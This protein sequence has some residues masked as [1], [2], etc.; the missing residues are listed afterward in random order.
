VA[1]GRATLITLR[2]PRLWIA[3]V[4]FGGGDI[5]ARV[6]AASMPR[7]H[8]VAGIFT[9]MLARGGKMQPVP[10]IGAAERGSVEGAMACSRSTRA[11]PARQLSCHL[12]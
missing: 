2:P 10:V 1:F 3:A 5:Q 4:S 12:W 7:C 11:S 8:R 6:V 9:W